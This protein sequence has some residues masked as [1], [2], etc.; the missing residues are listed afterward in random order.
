[1]VRQGEVLASGDEH[2][3]AARGYMPGLSEAKPTEG[4]EGVAIDDVAPGILSR[5]R[6]TRARSL[7]TGPPV[8]PRAEGRG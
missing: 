3:G 5:L 1:M 6:P 8:P 7:E 4:A 2:P